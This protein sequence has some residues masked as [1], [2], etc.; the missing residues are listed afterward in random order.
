MTA[1]AIPD[2]KKGVA[3]QAADLGRRAL[4]HARAAV[5]RGVDDANALG[6]LARAWGQSI[7]LLGNE[8]EI[9]TRPLKAEYD[10]RRKRWRDAAKPWQDAVAIVKSAIDSWRVAESERALAALPAAVTPEEQQRAVSIL[11]ARPMAV[12]KHY[13]VRVVDERQ[14]ARRWWLIDQ[15]GLDARARADKEA[16]D[17]PGCELV[18]EERSTL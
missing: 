13:S 7:K 4:E 17:E 10:R 6:E 3:E 2:T 12:R 5:I 14:L 8:C 18:I 1:I 9:D 15:Q 11:T 16:F